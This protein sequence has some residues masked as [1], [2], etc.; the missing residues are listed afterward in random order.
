MLLDIFAVYF[1]YAHSVLQG[2]PCYAHGSGRVLVS[3]NQLLHKTNSLFL[4]LCEGIA[5]LKAC[6]AL[7]ATE[8]QGGRDGAM[9]IGKSANGHI[10]YEPFMFLKE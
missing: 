3:S 10:L 8:F 5:R 2:H 7:Q 1:P 9:M 6:Q 4:K